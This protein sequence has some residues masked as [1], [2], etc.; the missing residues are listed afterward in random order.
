M[1]RDEEDELIKMRIYSLKSRYQTYLQSMR[2]SSFV[3]DYVQL[4]YY[5]CHEINLNCGGSNI[6]SPDWIKN[7]FNTL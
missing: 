1:I 2:G 5:K 4:F 7:V 6:D 3:I